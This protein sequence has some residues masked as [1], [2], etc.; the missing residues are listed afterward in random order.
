LLLVGLCAAVLLFDFSL[1]LLLAEVVDAGF[2]AVAEVVGVLFDLV[3]G[4]PAGGGEV[5]GAGGLGLAEALALLFITVFGHG[6]LGLEGSGGAFVLFA[7]ADGDA[8]GVAVHFHDGLLGGC[9][10]EARG[11]REEAGGDLA[12]V[13]GGAG[14][15]GLE[16]AGEQAFHDLGGDELDGGV[17]LEEG[18]AETP[19]IGE[20]GVTVVGVLDAEVLAAE[21]VAVALDAV[22]AEGTAAAEGGVVG[23]GWLGGEV[24]VHGGSFLRWW[25]PASQRE[26]RLVA[27]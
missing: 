18:D 22:G 9:G 19:G 4:E 23:G 14:V 13:E 12:A 6:P 21:G 26:T 17:V 5:G 1:L 10:G 7:G 20:G 2:V 15:G 27:G 24:C 11:A 3:F 16:L 8:F 25:F